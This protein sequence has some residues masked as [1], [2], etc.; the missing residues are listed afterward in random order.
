MQVEQHIDFLT[1][2][3][4]SAVRPSDLGFLDGGVFGAIESIS[5]FTHYTHAF[6]LK[7]GGVLN[8]SKESSQGC[9]L[10]LTG[11][12]LEYLRACGLHD[13]QILFITGQNEMKK[14]TTRL[15][16]CWT[17]ANAGS[18]RH[19]R[20]HWE[21]GKVRTTFRNAPLDIGEVG[22][23]R[24]HQL[25][26]G[27]RS[28]PQRAVVYDKAWEMGALYEALLR[29]ELRTRAPFAGEFYGDSLKTSLPIAARSRLANLLEFPH[30][31]WW[32]RAMSGE[33][34]TVGTVPKPASKWRK[35]LGKQVLGSIEKHWEDNS[36]DDR[37][38]LG[39]WLKDA[40]RIILK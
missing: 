16:Y 23:R 19:C 25:E 8:M 36:M 24:G 12:N 33:K 5:P 4:A 22:E 28:S 31:Q 39:E 21:A 26:F 29:V 17:I 40:M 30:L 38:F 34:C 3:Y 18:V 37:E 10:D 1:V 20:N 13:E 9:R 35:W 11:D 6:R 7:C 32:Q 2:S 27:S 14:R 15:D